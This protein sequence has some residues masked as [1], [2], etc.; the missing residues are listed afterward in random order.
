MM[1]ANQ[2]AGVVNQVAS[3]RFGRD[4]EYE[5][6]RI[7]VVLMARAGYNPQQMIGVLEI[8]KA[9]SGGGRPPEMLSTHP[10]PENRIQR[11]KELL[12]M[13]SR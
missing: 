7:G 11:I 3:T 9:A 5:S 13:G 4:D 2:V 1:T 6:D 8:L 12:G 10:Y